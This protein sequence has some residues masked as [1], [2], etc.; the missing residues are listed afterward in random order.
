MRSMSEQEMNETIGEGFWSNLGFIV[1]FVVTLIL[2]A[3][4]A[5]A[6]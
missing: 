3:E 1:G 6:T 4:I 5:G 2:A